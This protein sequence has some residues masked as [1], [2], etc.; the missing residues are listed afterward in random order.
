[1]KLIK[2]IILNIAVCAVIAG[3]LYLLAITAIPPQQTASDRQ[4][5]LMKH[6]GIDYAE[7]AQDGSLY[8]W[9]DGQRIK[10]RP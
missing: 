6:H 9:R 10:V 7:I 3:L 5:A 2:E 1:M 8:F 4:K